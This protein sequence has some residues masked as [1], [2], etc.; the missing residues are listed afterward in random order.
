MEEY[1]VNIIYYNTVTENREM[2]ETVAIDNDI[3]ITYINDINEIYSTITNS[4]YVGMVFIDYN[5][6]EEL[7]SIISSLYKYDSDLVIYIL[8]SID[9]EE[10]QINMY[11][12]GVTAYLITPVSSNILC[13]R[14]KNMA[15]LRSSRR[16]LYTV[17]NILQEEVEESVATIK[18]RELESL[19]LL[20]K[21]SEYKD[22]D[23]GN[24]ILRVGRYSAMIMEKLGGSNEAQELMLYSA[25][26]HDVGKIGIPDNILNK[27]GKLTDEEYEFMKTHTTKGYELLSGSKSKYLDAGAVIALSHHEK[28]DGSGYPRGL[29]GG[30]IPFYGRIVAIADVFDAL[31]SERVYKNSWTLEQTISYIKEQ[32]GIHFDPTIVDVFLANI[33]KAI[34]IMKNLP[35]K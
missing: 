8:S 3:E 4:E 13:Y 30:D 14:L 26:L 2:L 16:M 19:L 5:G 35:P 6:E 7:V 29:K 11:K 21:A 28:Y 18:E 9:S 15:N 10:A 12:A 20:G 25:P 24:H 27:N 34:N 33:D 23:T 17:R 32:S 22:A 31:M 1:G